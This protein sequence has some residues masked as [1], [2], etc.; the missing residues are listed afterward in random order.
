M[1]GNDIERNLPNDLIAYLSPTRLHIRMEEL[2]KHPTGK[3]DRLKNSIREFGMLGVVVVDKNGVVVAGEL[4]TKAAIELRIEQIPVL[5]ATHLSPA[6]IRAFRIAHNRLAEGSEWNL[7]ELTMEFEAILVDEPGFNLELTGFETPQIDLIADGNSASDPADFD[8]MEPEPEAVTRPGDLWRIKGHLLLCGDAKSARSHHRLMGSDRAGLVVT[9]PPFGVPVSNISSLCRRDFIEGGDM[10]VDEFCAFLSASFRR[11][12]QSVCPG[13]LLYSFI[14]WRGVDRLVSCCRDEGQQLFQMCVWDK[15]SGGQG[16]FYRSQH[17]LVVVLKEPGAK[18][19]NNIQLGKHGRNRTNV[20]SIPGLNRNSAERS[21]LLRSHPTP[22]P[23]QLLADIIK[24][25]S[26]LGDIVLD[27]FVGSGSTLIAA[28]IT[29]RQA[30]AIEKDPHYVDLAIRR[31]EQRFA[32]E[33]RHVTT[34]LT[35]AELSRQRLTK[36]RPAKSEAA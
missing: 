31:F 28:E 22:K 17:E 1:S 36:P 35:F 32:V 30:R 25:A 21:E 23:I 7:P 15:G 3:L 4:M 2:R 5:R 16:S 24:D 8:E 18:H 6:Q 14:D 33:A 27:P 10:S 9:D 34:G 19:V 12:R 20:W 29:K 13:A 11:M 26:R